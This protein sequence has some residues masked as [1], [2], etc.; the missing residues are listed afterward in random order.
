MHRQFLIAIVAALT[1]AA[2]K[3]DVGKAFI[4]GQWFERACAAGGGHYDA[5]PNGSCPDF[6]PR[7]LF[8]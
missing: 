1:L 7:E 2:C 4:Q 6:S 5:R 8:R 3:G